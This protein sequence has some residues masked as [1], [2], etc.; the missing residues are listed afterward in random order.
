M[1]RELSGKGKAS[2]YI[3]ENLGCA[4]CAAKM[5]KK[6]NELDYIEDAVITFATK[7]LRV[8]PKEEAAAQDL[9]A[10]F[11]EICASIEPEVKVVERVRKKKHSAHEQGVH[12]QEG[13]SHEHSDTHEKG[14]VREIGMGAI[15]FILGNLT[16]EILPMISLG[17][18]VIAYLILGSKIVLTAAKNLKKG[19]VFDENFLMSIA[20][21]GAFLIQEY[22]EAVGV[23]LFYR[24]GE[25]FEHAAVEKSRKQIMDA[26]DMRPEVVNLVEGSDISVVDAEE[27]SNPTPCSISTL[28]R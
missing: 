5:E 19:H 17:I 16:K 26:V 21:I 6:I 11:Q 18:F 4:N 2:V 20:T 23:M 25:Y 1:T 8:I 9:I 15:L 22:P 28:P 27:V 14:A 3:I 13:H 12:N 7:Q 10:V 24:I